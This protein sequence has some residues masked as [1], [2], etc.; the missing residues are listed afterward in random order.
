MIGSELKERETGLVNS[1]TTPVDR[2][3]DKALSTLEDDTKSE[4][5]EEDSVLPLD[6]DTNE[7]IARNDENALPT[8]LDDTPLEEKGEEDSVNLEE[9]KNSAPDRDD[10]D[11]ND[12]NA[13]SAHSF[14]Q[15]K[16]R[17]F[18]EETNENGEKTFVVLND[19]GS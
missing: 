13:L 6:V 15:D 1:E 17:S 18:L 16:T 5:R 3:D 14:L 9:M 2:N 4:G 8:L 11:G 7:N 12:S 19:L 10:E